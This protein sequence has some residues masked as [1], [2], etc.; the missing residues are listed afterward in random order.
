LLQARSRSLLQAREDVL[1][2]GRSGLWYRLCFRLRRHR[3]SG[4]DRSCSDR[5]AEAAGR[6]RSE[7]GH[8]ISPFAIV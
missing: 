8:V 6:S 4:H 1:R 3:C 5:S 2:S 7:A